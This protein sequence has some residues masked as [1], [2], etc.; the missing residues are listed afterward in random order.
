MTTIA[1]RPQKGTWELFYKVKGN[2][3]THQTTEN[4]IKIAITNKQIKEI[5]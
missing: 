3:Y 4:K 2:Y 5:I 1:P